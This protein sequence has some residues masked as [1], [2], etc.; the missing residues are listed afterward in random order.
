M[1]IDQAIERAYQRWISEQDPVQLA[2]ALRPSMWALYMGVLGTSLTLLTSSHWTSS[3]VGVPTSVALATLVPSNVVR[4]AF[5]LTGDGRR[6]PTE[7]THLLVLAGS[8]ALAFIWAALLVLTPGPVGSAFGGLYLFACAAEGYRY[9]A[10]FSRLFMPLATCLGGVAALPLT[11]SPGN[12]VALLA[13]LPA[14]LFAS[15]FMG[16]TALGHDAMRREKEAIAEALSSQMLSEQGQR[17]ADLSRRMD[18]IYGRQHDAKNLLAAMRFNTTV[19]MDRIQEIPPDL[20]E[21]VHDVAEAA[22]RMVPLLVVRPALDREVP[23]Q[24]ANV[25]SVVSTVLRDVRARYPDVHL[26]LREQPRDLEVAVVHG[27]ETLERVLHN[28]I[29]NACEG[30]T[31]GRAS[32]V[33]L[34]VR[35]EED[36][37]TLEVADDGPGFAPEQLEGPIT[38]YATTKERG[39]GLG[40]YTVERLVWASG[41]NLRRSNRDEGGALVRVHLRYA[42]P[43]LSH[44]ELAAV[45]G[46]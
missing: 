23:N 2:T 33:W 32:H 18:D 39:T 1:R 13:L 7:L 22:T 5:A 46:S 28:L 36:G 37:A 30:G 27:A 6:I 21:V 26:E 44:V 38:P 19:L 42:V 31:R 10:S 3:W 12:S 17:V 35:R 20:A 25:G 16:Q 14:G 24:P 29:I 41:G 43:G 11:S 40:L 45:R 8:A 4:L 9:R 34:N 15:A